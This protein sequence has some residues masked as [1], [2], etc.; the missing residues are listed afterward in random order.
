MG[1][2]SDDGQA[3]MCSRILLLSLFLLSYCDEQCPMVANLERIMEKVG[4]KRHRKD[5]RDN[6]QGIKK[7]AV[8]R[9]HAAM[10]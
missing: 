1:C 8:R 6:I 7:S 3:Q 5:L 4:D 10:E 2:C 9:W